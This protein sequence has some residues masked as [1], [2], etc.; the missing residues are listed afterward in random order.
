[1][2]YLKQ[3]GKTV[4]IMFKCDEC[5]RELP[6]KESTLFEGLDFKLLCKDCREDLTTPLVGVV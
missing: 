4:Y 1:M 6:I 2:V 3:E 5:G